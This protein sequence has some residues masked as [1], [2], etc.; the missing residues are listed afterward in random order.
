MMNYL[1]QNLH[2]HRPFFLCFCFH[3]IT[4]SHSPIVPKSRCCDL[5]LLF[6]GSGFVLHRGQAGNSDYLGR[7]GDL[8][9]TLPEELI[10]HILSFLPTKQVVATS[11]L[12]KRWMPLWR[13]VSTLDFDDSD[14]NGSKKAYARFVQSV[15]AFIVSRDMHLPIEKVRLNCSSY[16]CDPA[17][18]SEWVNVVVQHRVQHLDLWLPLRY[19]YVQQPP[20]LSSIFTCKTLVV[21]KLHCTKLEPISSVDLPFLKL[22]HLKD[23]RF[24]KRAC[25][26]ELLS[27]CPILEDFKAKRLY[28]HQ[29]VADTEFKT[30][31]KLLGLVNNVKFLRIDGIARRLGNGPGP[32][33]FPM[34]HNLTH[35]ELEYRTYNTDWSEVVELLK[36][37]PKLQVLIIN[38]PSIPFNEPDLLE[39]PAKWQYPPSVPK[40]I[41][42]H[43][44]KCCLNNFRGTKGEFQFAKY[45]MRNGR[46]LKRMT[47]SS[48]IFI[49][50]GGKVEML[51]KL[52]CCMRSSATCKLS[53][54]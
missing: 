34:F 26:A 8:V 40:C 3:R 13:S 41:L 30:L 9:S 18:V 5:A 6:S 15:Y 39:K 2:L 46:F 21:L 17:T 35:V 53:F 44:K 42:L 24:S 31:P 29:D 49:N 1:T 11:I 10:C 19:L 14:F 54:N 50:Q 16:V 33:V 37:C 27:G 32:Y 36:C 45:I 4:L 25:L 52:S 48:G 7:M 28:F 38:Q 47:I 22:L 20:N 43:L 23:L 12:S 51:K